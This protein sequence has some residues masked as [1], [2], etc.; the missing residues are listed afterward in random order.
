MAQEIE[1]DLAA[2]PAQLGRV[3]RAISPSAESQAFCYFLEKYVPREGRYSAPILEYLV[4]TITSNS[5]TISAI[6]TAAGMAG[7]SAVRR[8]A[9][10]SMLARRKYAV[11]LQRTKEH[12][13]DPV[14]AKSD[15][16]FV[17][18]GYLA[19]FEV[20]RFDP[21]KKIL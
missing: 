7:L 16:T 17:A 21:I 18:V 4:S 9:K 8:D 11:A 19:V 6:I 13:Q 2:M 14:E 3:Q 12:L 10:L 5:Q 20:I 15:M 1:V